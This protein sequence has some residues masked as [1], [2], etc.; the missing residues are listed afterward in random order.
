MDEREQRRLQLVGELMRL[1]GN[2]ELR[3]N[4]RAMLPPLTGDGASPFIVGFPDDTL[5][6]I[7]QRANVLGGSA[8]LVIVTELPGSFRLRILRL[9]P[10]GKPIG[11]L[12]E[13]RDCPVS[14]DST[15]EMLLQHI[16]VG[17][18]VTYHTYDSDTV[19]RFLT[20]SV[21]DVPA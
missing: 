2:R 18:R 19:I 14:E 4:F 10:G 7:R 21:Q 9:S 16:Q 15:L 6:D 8:H 20:D 5:R 11:D 13:D 1:A 17:G 12:D 3:H